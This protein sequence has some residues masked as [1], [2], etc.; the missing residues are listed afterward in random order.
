[1]DVL[2]LVA[3]LTLDK[4]QYEQG[5][6]EAESEASS[7]GGRL[8]KVLGGVGKAVGT[9]AKVTAAGIGAGAAAVGVLTKQSIDA[10]ASYEQLAG[11]VETLFGNTYSSAEEWAKATGKTL[12][13]AG[14]EWEAYQS[15]AQDVINNANNAYK[16]AGMSANDYMETVTS[17]AASLNASLGENAWQSANYA[18]MAITDMSDN[19]NKM[20]TSMESIQNAYMG[21]SKQNYTMLDNLKLGYGG[22]KEEMERLLRDAEEFNGL[23]VGAYQIENFADIVDAIHAVQ[24]NLGIT[25]TT[26]DEAA[27]TIEGSLN[28]VK[29]AWN[30]LVAGFA[31]PDADMDQLMNNLV[32]AIVGE[33][34]GEGLLNQLIPAVE[35][36][37]RGIGDF[38]VKAA[39]IIAQRLPALM[40]AILPSLIKAAT[41]LVA[42][43][44]KALPS[45]LQVL[46]E[47]APM[48]ISMLAQALRETAPLLVE[49][50][51]NLMNSIYNGLVNAFPQLQGALDTV[52]EIFKTAFDGI[53]TAIDF[54][55]EHID[56]IAP[57]VAAVVG[58][59]AGLGI[60]SIISGL[61][62]A[63]TG[64]ATAI[65][66]VISA[67]SMIKSFAGLISV[68]TTLA[69]GPL[70]LIVA[71]IGAVAGAFIYLWN[72]SEEFRN[73]WIGLWEGIKE[74]VSSAWDGIKSFVSSAID[75]VKRAIDGLSA[76]KDTVFGVFND[77]YNTITDKLNS[78]WDF[79][80][81]IVEKIKGVFNFEW[82]LPD[83]KLPHINVGAYIDVPALGTIPD[84]RYLT[85]D[86]Y[87][88]AY[89]NPWMFT[90]PTVM[91]DGRGYGDGNGG[92]VVY[93]HANLMQDI[94]DA[95]GSVG[96]RVF[97]PVININGNGLNTQEIVD[98]VMEEM[99]AAY[100]RADK[101]YA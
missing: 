70:V 33:N 2:A 86:W 97:A 67:L 99:E 68:I 4:S 62:G 8:G 95:M 101:V 43:L 28:T 30:N 94:K 12:D 57:I 36:A 20:G 96:Q 7:A 35:R 47:Q 50:G 18:D 75:G 19:A 85:V 80:S 31:N 5:L 78:A 55:K 27:K 53:T 92:E 77:V 61:V 24:E 29:G 25:G 46:I 74:T 41:A 89:N 63:I 15:R 91:P 60:L 81:G 6:G 52:I 83:L 76:I 64:I 66:G 45:I 73:F 13:E 65:G 71:A 69:G 87:A 23:E 44:V 49:L 17:F 11:G 42:G 79:I 38:V 32:V 56:T 21:F 48:I 14:Y 51:K 34:E 90:K 3:R 82:K 59:I 100:N 10:Y 39:P 1:M 26:S 93:G 37:L 84:P 58:A 88:K 40:R 98:R 22:T 72:T 9:A 16:T 54:V